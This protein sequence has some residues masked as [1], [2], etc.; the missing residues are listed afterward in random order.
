MFEKFRANLLVRREDD[1]SRQ[2]LL[3]RTERCA[4]PRNGLD[5]C[6]VRLLLIGGLGEQR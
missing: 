3:R 6:A 5:L 2:Q 1:E 4:G